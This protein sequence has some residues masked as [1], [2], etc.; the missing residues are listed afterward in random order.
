MKI[1]Y[2]CNDTSILPE[3]NII[4]INQ[5]GADVDV[6]VIYI[7]WSFSDNN[8]ILY[9]QSEIVEKNIGKTPIIIFDKEYNLLDSEI[10]F[11]LAKGNNILL[12]PSLINRKGFRYFPHWINLDDIN[13]IKYLDDISHKKIDI[14]FNQSFDRRYKQFEEFILNFAKVN[15][16]FVIAYVDEPVIDRKIQ[17]EKANIKYMKDATY[18]DAK[19]T[20]MSKPMKYY[21][22]G[23]LTNEWVEAA[24]QQTIPLFT[25]YNKYYY[26]LFKDVTVKNIKD[27]EYIIPKWKYIYL[28]VFDS[29]KNNI[30]KDFNEM[31]IINCK[32]RFMEV[33][34]EKL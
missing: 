7:E 5:K 23:N 30:S 34:N 2:L 11:L 33:I 15:E 32:K 12:E 18:N 21:N 6:D 19:F 24:K 9:R 20:F 10:N 31:N 17:Y 3:N 28:G 4:D 27:L 22:R 1:G 14:L 26:Q 25:K 16:E 29:L 13:N 8:K